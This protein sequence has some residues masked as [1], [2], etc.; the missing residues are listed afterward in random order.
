LVPPIYDSNTNV[1]I[2]PPR[3]RKQSRF[4]EVSRVS[5]KLLQL[6][7]CTRLASGRIFSYFLFVFLWL[8][9]INL[10]CL[11]V[12]CT[13]LSFSAVDNIKSVQ[14]IVNIRLAHKHH[15]HARLSMVSKNKLNI[16]NGESVKIVKHPRW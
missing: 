10:D 2:H 4:S 8:S 6:L 3:K 7:R 15:K 5:R 13:Q 14:G 9:I 12:M 16:S 11:F 1:Y